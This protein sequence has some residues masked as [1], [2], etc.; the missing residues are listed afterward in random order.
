MILAAGEQRIE[1]GEERPV[2]T[3]G[4][5]A[6]NDLV[7]KRSVVSRRHARVEY[8]DGQF[9]LI[10][11]SSNGTYVVAASGTS[12]YLRRKRCAL[13]GAGMIGLGE[14]PSV[15]SPV[16][17]QYDRAPASFPALDAAVPGE[18]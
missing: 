7:V 17:L 9:L 6:E 8:A 5:S 2:V 4:R 3:L 13:T 1:V 14:A 12:T 11:Q 15:G 10:D 16:T 18:P